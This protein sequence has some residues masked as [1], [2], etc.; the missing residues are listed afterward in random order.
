MKITRKY[1]LSKFGMRYENIEI[2]TNE[3]E[4]IES[5][6]KELQE[7]VQILYKTLNYKRQAMLE[8]LK[9]KASH[10]PEEAEL[11]EKLKKDLVL[12]PF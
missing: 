8:E 9:K 7:F 1:D 4:D 2:T 11:Y 6:L 3:H 12:P 5:C 10:T